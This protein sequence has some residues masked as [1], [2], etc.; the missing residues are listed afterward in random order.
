MAPKAAEKWD[1]TGTKPDYIAKVRVK[2]LEPM[3]GTVP[4]NKKVYEEYI[5]E[6][7]RKELAR[8][9]LDDDQRKGY[10]DVLDAANREEKETIVETDEKGYTGFH[11]D[12][13]A[14]QLFVY[15]YWI[16]GFLKSALDALRDRKNAKIAQD[17]KDKDGGTKDEAKITA[18]KKLI[19][20]QV[21][22]YPRRILLGKG[23]PDGVIERPLRA[24]TAQGPR[25]CLAKSDY[26]KAGSEFGFD[27]HVL[28]KSKM[29]Q[30]LLTECLRYGKSNGLGQFRNGSY[31]QFIFQVEFE[32]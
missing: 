6:K 20:K 8:K 13:V 14:Q 17:A 19:D 18:Y 11:Y 32:E 22:I 21:F 23:I 5:I 2:L 7:I 28:N 1:D 29:P 9:D 4:K 26:I 12:A 24:E 25:V 27:I 10:Q 30:S 31:G 3:L 15:D 16:R